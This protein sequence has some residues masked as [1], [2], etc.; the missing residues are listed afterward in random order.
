MSGLGGE[1]VLWYYR[2]FDRDSQRSDVR[3]LKLGCDHPPEQWRP[4]FSPALE[5]HGIDLQ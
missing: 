2:L 4:I 1:F 5:A 3:F